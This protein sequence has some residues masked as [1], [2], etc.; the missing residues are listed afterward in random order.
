MSENSNGAKPLDSGHRPT[1]TVGGVAPKKFLLATLHGMNKAFTV[2]IAKIDAE[3][4]RLQTER[5]DHVRRQ[6]QLSLT[7]HAA[8][9]PVVE[10]QVRFLV[11]NLPEFLAEGVLVHA[12]RNGIY[13]DLSLHYDNRLA[14]ITSE[15]VTVSWGR[16]SPS[17]GEP[18]PTLPHEEELVWLLLT[19][20]TH[21]RLCGSQ[22]ALDIGGGW[23]LKRMDG[24]FYYRTHPKWLLAEQ[25]LD[26]T[27]AEVSEPTLQCTAE[28]FATLVSSK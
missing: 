7:I 20:A 26:P 8:E 14:E 27:T 15:H 9:Y 23:V 6:H 22:F 12:D 1:R 25:I 18:A 2:D 28:T 13:W 5:E 3:I 4:A 11:G 24:Q 21:D 16:T 10:R 17:L 19:K